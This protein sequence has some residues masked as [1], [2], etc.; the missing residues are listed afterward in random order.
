MRRRLI[1]TYLAITVFVLLAIEVPFGVLL[2]QSRWDRVTV[3]LERDAGVLATVYEDALDNGAAY[4]P[5]AAFDYAERTGTR[6]VIVDD[7][8]V[9]IVD[10]AGP[11]NRNFSNRPE[12]ASALEGERVTG[13]RS[14]TTLGEELIYVAV[15]V[16]SGGVVHGAVRLTLNAKTYDSSVRQVWWGLGATALVVLAG[17]AAAG[18]VLAASTV[19]PLRGLSAAVA[20][21]RATGAPLAAEG[22]EHAPPELVELASAFTDMGDRVN[23]VVDRHRRFVADASHQLRSPLTALRLQ[24]E[25]LA[26]DG[27]HPERL[28]TALAEVDRLTTLVTQLLH[29]ARSEGSR[30]ARVGIDLN[31]TVKDRCA[32]WEAVAEESGSTIE[33][34]TGSTPLQVSLPEGAV[35]QVLDNLL[36]NAIAVSPAGSK[37]RVVVTAGEG[38]AVIHVQDQ[39]PGLSPEDRER[40]FE[41]FWTGPHSTGSSGL[42]LA[43]VS[44]LVIESGGS[45]RLDPAPGGGVDAVVELPR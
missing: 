15:P 30:A 44:E 37:V 40:A 11:A 42:G 2:V 38:A 35:D 34:A 21:F 33:V 5:R 43:I 6:V 12:I 1:L 19:R 23:D 8:G 32:L 4:G 45:V 3:G 24:L 41:R 31:A 26:A 17:T 39:G 9:S 29:L 28:D 7:A 22:I 10:S 27:E 14:S 20:R 25:N 16:A 18:W 36:S 13:R